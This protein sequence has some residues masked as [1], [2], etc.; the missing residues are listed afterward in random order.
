MHKNIELITMGDLGHFN[1]EIVERKGKGHPDTLADV[2]AEELSKEYSKYTLSKFGAVLHHNFD[3]VGL[4][5][6]KAKVEFG[7][8]EILQPIR[9]LLNGRASSKFG[10]EEIDVKSLLISTTRNFFE[11]RFPMIN[12][13]KDVKILYEVSTG[14]SPGGIEGVESKRHRWFE[15]TSL[16]DLNELKFLNCNDTSMGCAFFG[17]TL[18]EKIVLD[19]ENYL[20]SDEY[21]K[22][23]PWIG[24][25]IKIMG[26]KDE[27]NEV[28]LTM[29]IPQLCGRVNSIEEY[30]ANK[31]QLHDDILKLIADIDKSVVINLFINTRDK[32]DSNNTDLYL[33]FT[34]SSIEMGD[35][36][37]VGRGNRMGGL[38]TP[39]RFYTMEGICGKNPI[40]HTGKMYSVAS[41]EISKGIS[42]EFNCNCAVEIV[43]QSGQSLS[44][45]W[46]VAIFTDKDVD[47][48]LCNSIAAKVLDNFPLISQNIL[49]GKYPMV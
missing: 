49:N 9:V 18:L 34:G 11:A 1:Y 26:V 46:K 41:Y 10:N 7:K 23:N 40:Y 44:N 15:P 27:K 47:M 3:K 30:I 20:N 13:D 22:T 42:E 39:R 12:F 14:S 2:L 48:E 28:F 17:K 45:P 6:G 36:G 35:E 21:K 37:F 19:V 33:T 16:E 4:M 43:G 38:I 5:G 8:G 31:N 29:A 24:N 25:D 32:I